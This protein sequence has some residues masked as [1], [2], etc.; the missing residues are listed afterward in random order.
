MWYGFDV[1]EL[2]HD[3]LLAAFLELGRMHKESIR[4]HRE[5]VELFSIA[6]QNLAREARERCLT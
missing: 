2:S 4:R 1:R 3:E 5:T 6:N